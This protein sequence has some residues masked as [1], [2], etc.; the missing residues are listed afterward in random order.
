MNEEKIEKITFYVVAIIALLFAVKY[1]QESTI[2]NLAEEC[3]SLV[4][5][6]KVE[7][8]EQ[9]D[10]EIERNIEL[11]SS[12]L[13]LQLENQR[14]EEIN[15]HQEVMIQEYIFERMRDGFFKEYKEKW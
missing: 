14:L 3:K 9:L 8:Q 11:E 7:I 13:Q 15:K 5:H 10:L 1:T 2:Y 6:E 12:I 4:E